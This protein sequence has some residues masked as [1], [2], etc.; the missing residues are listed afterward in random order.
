MTT[1]KQGDKVRVYTWT[2][3][4]K[5]VGVGRISEVV[6]WMRYYDGPVA[7]INVPD[8]SGRFLRSFGDLEMAK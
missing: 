5:L 6:P 1:F 4:R 3:P 2:S 7:C 8:H